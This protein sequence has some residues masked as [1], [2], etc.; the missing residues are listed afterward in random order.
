MPTIGAMHLTEARDDI[1]GETSANR[2]TFLSALN[3]GDATMAS[4]VYHENALLLSPTGDVLSGRAAIERFWQS[5]I[6]IGLG[7]VE[8]RPLSHSAWG[9]LI[10]E[11]GLYQMVLTPVADRPA[12]DRGRYLIVHV[13]SQG[14]WRWAV[15]AFGTVDATHEQG[16]TSSTSRRNRR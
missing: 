10:Y 15:S 1:R 9:A 5:G 16:A 3:R 6:E 14:S 11:D 12:A 2:D 13:Q 7:A 4:S 8:L